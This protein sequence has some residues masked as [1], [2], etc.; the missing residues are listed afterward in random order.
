MDLII[1]IY[2]YVVSVALLFGRLIQLCS[3]RVPFPPRPLQLMNTV[4]TYVVII[5]QVGGNN[6]EKFLFASSGPRNASAFQK[7]E[8][9]A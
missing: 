7:Q 2:I 3:S 6:F 4:L 9:D 8:T 5:F 1:Y